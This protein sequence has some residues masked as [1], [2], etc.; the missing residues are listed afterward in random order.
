MQPDMETTVLEEQKP[1][2]DRASDGLDTIRSLAPRLKRSPRTVQ[3]WM[4]EGKLPYM[5]VGK[6][7][8]FR[9][10]DVVRK[11]NSYRVN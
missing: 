7:V 10:D 5:K 2:T 4:R 9:W 6:S 1:A 3:A 8:L 11:L